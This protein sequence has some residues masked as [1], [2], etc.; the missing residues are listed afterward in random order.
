MN[1]IPPIPKIKIDWDMSLYYKNEKDSKIEE[2]LRA[3]EQAYLSFAKKWRKKD[4]VNNPKN[5]A[6]A[7][8]E[9]ESMI[10]NPAFSR[11]MRYFYLRT[12]L[13]TGDMAAIKQLTLIE[14]RL[15]EASNHILFFTIE[16]GKADKKTQTMLLKAPELRAYK[17]YLERL[18]L[19]AKHHLTEAEEKIISLK[20]S[21]SYGRWTDMTDRIISE[22]KI[23]WEGKQVNLPHAFEMMEETSFSKKP[24]LWSAISKELIQ[25]S[26]V[27]EHEFNAIIN[28]V[29]SEEKLRKY[30][31]PY[32]STALG[33]QDKEKSIEQLVE[34]VSKK[35][36]KLSKEF[37]KLKAEYH[38]VEKLKYSQRSQTAGDSIRIPF[39]KAVDVC[40]EVFYEVKPEY[41]EF[42]DSMLKNGQIDVFPKPGKSGGAFMSASQ[43]HPINVFLNHTSDYNSMTTLAH[44][45][46]HAIHSYVATK[47][48]TPFYQDYSIIV[49]ETASTL[50]EGLVFNHLLEKTDEKDM[51]KLL[52]DKLLR[53][54]AT[55]QRQIAFFNCELEIHQTIEKNGA[56]SGR[57]LALC[58]QK[59]LKSYLGSAVE[60]TEEDGYTYT[61]VRHLRYGFYVFTYAYGQL[62]SSLI[63]DEYKNDKGALKKIE[64]FMSAGE[65]K[66]VADIYKEIGFDTTKAETFIHSLNKMEEDIKT[67]KK[68]LKKTGLK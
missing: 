13:N 60:V 4:F 46:G 9:K 5:L 52:H 22:R 49:A 51:I 67:F 43:G 57:E 41:G 35:G 20:S 23:M 62:M 21:Q 45:M 15:R 33:Y 63:A 7:L 47:S 10:G 28:D 8:K 58:M 68:L 30:E 25:I 19:S 18:F 55:V 37:Y 50:F 3:T 38:G 26:E 65:S 39:E 42:F 53:D 36:F 27:A 32:S 2:D 54:I 31:K 24:E 44:E 11:G 66:T 14:K 61:Y 48:Q 64:T 40:R 12:A 6:L 29:R 17:Y 16:L 1:K 59:H 34:V 56:M